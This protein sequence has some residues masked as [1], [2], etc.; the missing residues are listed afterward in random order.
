MLTAENTRGA[1]AFRKFAE[2]RGPRGFTIAELASATAVKPSLTEVAT[3]VSEAHDSG[4]LAETRSGGTR[5][6]HVA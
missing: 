4:Y 5:R 1:P 3:W 6:Y 2:H